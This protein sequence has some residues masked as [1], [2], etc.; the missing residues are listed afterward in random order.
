MSTNSSPFSRELS[1]RLGPGNLRSFSKEIFQMVANIIPGAR[2]LIFG[3]SNVVK[4][5]PGASLVSEMK[6]K[7]TMKDYICD[8]DGTKYFLYGKMS[9]GKFEFT[10]SAAY[11]AA[12]SEYERIKVKTTLLLSQF[13]TF[14]IANISDESLI[15]MRA[16]SG[17]EWTEIS[18]DAER[19]WTLIRL[20]HKLNTNNSLLSAVNMYFIRHTLDGSVA[21]FCNDASDRKNEFE[22]VF[23]EFLDLPLRSITEMLSS[24]MFVDSFVQAGVLPLTCDHF[25]NDASSV[26]SLSKL[27]SEKNSQ[28]FAGV[29]K[30]FSQASKNSVVQTLDPSGV[31]CF[32]ATKLDPTIKTSSYVCANCKESEK[33]AWNPDGTIIRRSLCNTC[34]RVLRLFKAI[35]ADETSKK[36]SAL[37]QQKQTP[38]SAPSSAAIVKGKITNTN[39]PSNKKVLPT[40]VIPASFPPSS[41]AAAAALAASKKLVSFSA[42]SKNYGLSEERA[43]YILSQATPDDQEGS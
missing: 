30:T 6:A 15:S 16:S 29:M 38:P 35:P 24:L 17:G 33:T 12:L 19:L 43:A 8:E 39:G 13:L 11:N 2:K 7:P 31:V 10:N 34:Y 32:A 42:V 41:V 5:E 3:E 40:N 4:L 20:S 9:D 25:I 14:T 18:I 27:S 26:L 36:T 23:S 37:S 22:S 21:S 28:L 1:A